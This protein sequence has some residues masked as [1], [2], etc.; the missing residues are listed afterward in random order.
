MHVQMQLYVRYVAKS[1][2]GLYLFEFRSEVFYKKTCVS[3]C[4]WHTKYVHVVIRKGE[5]EMLLLWY[6]QLQHELQHELQHV[7]SPT[8]EYVVL[9]SG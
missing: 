6:K 7:G 5:C 9:K 8:E 1:V 3:L 2:H 4:Q